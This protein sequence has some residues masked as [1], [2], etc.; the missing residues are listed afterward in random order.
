MLQAWLDAAM[1]RAEF[2]VIEN[3]PP[4]FGSVPECQGAW[5]VGDSELDCRA[6]LRQALESWALLGLRFGDPIPVID[7]VGLSAVAEPVVHG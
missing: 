2:E 7:G 5:A 4:W 6:E 1:A 3:D